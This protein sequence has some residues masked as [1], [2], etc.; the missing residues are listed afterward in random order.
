MQ[1]PQSRPSNPP[2]REEK[3]LANLDLA[4][5]FHRTNKEDVYGIDIAV[6]C[7]LQETRDAFAKAY[8]YPKSPHPAKKEGETL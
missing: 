5:E 3:F 1:P 8:G 2:S 4:I 7:A 6:M